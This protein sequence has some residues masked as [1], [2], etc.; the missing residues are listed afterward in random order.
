MVISFNNNISRHNN[1]KGT[2]IPVHIMKACRGVEL[3]LHSLTSV[4]DGGEWFQLLAFDRF[5]PWTLI[6]EVGR[7]YEPV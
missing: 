4:I 3:L 7:S 1:N 2:V 6:E 5:T